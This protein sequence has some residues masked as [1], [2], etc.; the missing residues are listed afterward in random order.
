MTENP[1]SSE[2][3]RLSNKVATDPQSRLFVQLADEYLK[4]GLM[5]EAIG[6]LSDGIQHHPTHV[7]ARIMLGKTYLKTKQMRQA[8]DEFEAVVQIYPE[9]IVAHKQLANIYREVGQLGEAITICNKILAIDPKDQETK[10]ALTSIQQE[11]S[12]MDDI[13]SLSP[14]E[15]QK[16]IAFPPLSASSFGRSLRGTETEVLPKKEAALVEQIKTGGDAAPAPAPAL[17]GSTAVH[18]ARLHGWLASMQENR[19]DGF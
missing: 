17:S 1:L 13:H 11:I 4:H 14:S 18:L 10:T 16:A 6:V 2:I 8:K 7:A 12:V 19:K 3:Q 9:N 15:P 5:E